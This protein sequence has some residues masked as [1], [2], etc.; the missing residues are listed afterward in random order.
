[1]ITIQVTS[2]NLTLGLTLLS[3][4]STYAIIILIVFPVAQKK[5]ISVVFK[6][7]NRLKQNIKHLRKGCST[8]E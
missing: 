2:L 7:L 4:A 8:N 1:V 5:T 3:I 6:L